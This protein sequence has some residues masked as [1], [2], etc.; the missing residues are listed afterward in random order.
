M[1]ELKFGDLRDSEERYRALIAVRSVTAWPNNE[2]ERKKYLATVAAHHL[3]EIAHIRK[4]GGDVPRGATKKPRSWFAE[5]GGMAAVSQA[6]SLETYFREATDRS[7]DWFAAGLILGLVRRLAVH[8]ADLRGGASVS[9]AIHI[10]DVEHA[11]WAP[12]NRRDLWQAW[13]T[14]KSVS[15]FC[16]AVF[17][18]F[19]DTRDK[20]PNAEAVG[21][22]MEHRLFEDFQMFCALAASYQEFGLAHVLPHSKG[23]RLLSA[24]ECWL[25]PRNEQWPPF[26]Y[27][28]QPLD[29]A[30]LRAA[31]AYNAL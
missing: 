5:G 30:L 16:A 8:H 7:R 25:L 31:H 28:A 10:L 13:K 24:E 20:A 11:P 6:P 19:M 23:Q 2:L 26:R 1:P 9:K 12:H 15:H 27:V 14:Y 3:G 29:G 22:M 4:Q 21:Q 17:D 18:I